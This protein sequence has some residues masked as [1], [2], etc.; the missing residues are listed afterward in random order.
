MVAVDVE[1]EEMGCNVGVNDREFI[2]VAVLEAFPDV[3]RRF[4]VRIGSEE[5]SLWF[6]SCDGML[7]V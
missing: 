6:V 1:D 3:R 5:S 2:S 7:T 4:G